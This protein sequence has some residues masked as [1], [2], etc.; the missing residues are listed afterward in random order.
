MSFFYEKNLLEEEKVCFY[1][2][3]NKTEHHFP[4]SQGI[5]AFFT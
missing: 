2:F 4:M 1:Y 5:Q 3:S